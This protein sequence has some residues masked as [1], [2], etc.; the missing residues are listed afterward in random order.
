MCLKFEYF[1]LYLSSLLTS[2]LFK[3]NF[4]FFF[5]FF[6]CVCWQRW[7]QQTKTLKLTL[8]KKKKRKK[9]TSSVFRI[10]DKLATRLFID[11]YDFIRNELGG[12]LCCSMGEHVTNGL[13]SQWEGG[14][15]GGHPWI[16]FAY[17]SIT[18]HTEVVQM[19]L[20]KMGNPNILVIPLVL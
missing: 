3:N 20:S 14:G 16:H 9:K 5:S 12:Y 4:F 1:S 13:P 17:I 11:H 19:D 2:E 18:S 8:K 15:R 10:M 6:W 7:G